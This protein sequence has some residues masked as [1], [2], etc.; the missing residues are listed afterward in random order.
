[1]P[2]KRSQI[3]FME[4]DDI[5]NLYVVTNLPIPGE[6]PELATVGAFSDEPPF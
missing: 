5:L 2:V 3:M 4:R 1:M 6:A